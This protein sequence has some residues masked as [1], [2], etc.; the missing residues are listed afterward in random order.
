MFV[1]GLAT[2]LS[3]V[4]VHATALCPGFVRTEF[5]ERAEMDVAGIPKQLWLTGRCRI[6]SDRGTATRQR[7]QRFLESSTGDGTNAETF[8]PITCPTESLP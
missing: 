3:D 7:A 5:H 2:E 8:S 1:E 6:Q 4:D